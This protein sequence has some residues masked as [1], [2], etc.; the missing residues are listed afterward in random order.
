[1]FKYKDTGKSNTVIMFANSPHLIR[2]LAE[3]YK[4]LPQSGRIHAPYVCVA[5]EYGL[6]GTFQIVHGN[7]LSV[8]IA[9]PSRMK[10]IRRF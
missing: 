5:S 10:N 2:G 6:P 1:M 8:C 9:I 7:A 3:D 4:R